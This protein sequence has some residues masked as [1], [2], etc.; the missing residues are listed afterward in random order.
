MISGARRER[1][2]GSAY[3]VAER[4]GRGQVISFAGDPH[5]RLFWRGTLPIFLNAALYSAT[6]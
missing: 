2:K 1:I 6:F 5:Y 3:V 4:V